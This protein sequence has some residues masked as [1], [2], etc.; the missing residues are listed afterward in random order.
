MRIAIPAGLLYYFYFPAWQCFFKELGMDVVTSGPTTK[1][2]VDL[3]TSRS[4]AEACI[5][6]KVY[7]GHVL[8]L[9]LRKDVD[10]LF[11]PRF[12]SIESKFHFCPKLMGLPD[13]IRNTVPEVLNKTFLEPW[14]KIEHKVNEL[15]P[16]AVLVGASLGVSA[17]MSRAAFSKAIDAYNDS[18]QLALSGLTQGELIDNINH[19]RSPQSTVSGD[20]GVLRVGVL[21]YAYNVYDRFLSMDIVN[22]LREMGVFVTTFEMIDYDMLRKLVKEFPKNLFWSFSDWILRAGSHLVKNGAVD[23]LIHVTSFGCGPDAIVGKMLDLEAK[24]YDIPYLTM[25][26]DEHTGE[27]HLLTRLEAF[28]DVLRERLIR[29]ETAAGSEVTEQ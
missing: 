8:S 20:P 27:A 25:R 17:K 12:C 28:V 14:I 6:I 18:R 29:V 4:V 11:V 9:A 15:M 16:T 2:I 7:T 1:H 10:A 23:G 24:K 19:G 3:G 21:G 26:I 5:P 13:M 22:K